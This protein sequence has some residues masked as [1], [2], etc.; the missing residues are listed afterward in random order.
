M[1]ETEMRAAVRWALN[2][3][4]DFTL[5]DILAAFTEAMEHRYATIRACPDCR[6]Q[7]HGACPQHEADSRQGFT[8][9]CLRESFERA[10]SDGN[11]FA[12]IT[13]VVLCGHGRGR[14][15]S[16]AETEQILAALDGRAAT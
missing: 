1:N 12:H 6:Q 9:M 13:R 5:A 3:H 2:S 10:S 15:P 16:A 11:E 4:P 7:P 14:S 8:Y